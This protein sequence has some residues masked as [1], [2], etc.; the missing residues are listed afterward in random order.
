MK[1]LLVEDDADLASRLLRQLADADFV[2]EWVQE[3]EEAMLWPDAESLAA[4]ILDLGL[5]GMG[6]LEF[7]RAWRAA[8]RQTPILV[9]SARSDW[10]EKVDCLNSGAEDYVVKPVRSEELVARVRALLRRA[11]KRPVSDWM[12]SGNIRLHPEM[13]VA[14]VNGQEIALSAMEF[15]LLQLLLRRQ[16]RVV[17]QQEVIEELY[18]L[19]VDRQTNTIEVHIAR[20]RR[21]IG[22]DSILNQRGLGYKLVA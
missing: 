21:K 8:G 1:I 10:Q 4:I 20:L 3:A 13:R 6:G 19:N 11:A 12:V 5:P 2:A 16:G 15:K 17:S 7:I 14:E 22:R 18:P 9:L